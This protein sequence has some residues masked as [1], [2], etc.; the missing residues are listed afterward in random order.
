M[1]TLLFCFGNSAV[2]R[3]SVGPTT[4]SR[5]SSQAKSRIRSSQSVLTDS[6]NPGG[7]IGFLLLAEMKFTPEESVWNHG[8]S[9]EK[10]L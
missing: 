3:A 6:R 9:A 7:R 1:H 8:G 5:R 4:P 10:V 2:R